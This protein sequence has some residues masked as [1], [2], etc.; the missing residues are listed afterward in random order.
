MKDIMIKITGRQYSGRDEDKVE[1][2]TA[3]TLFTEGNTT[4]ITYEETPLSGIEGWTTSLAI[5]PGKV[6]MFRKSDA[7][8]ETVMEF[9]KGRHYNGIY[10]TPYG[11]IS[12]ELLT[13][14]VSGF[15]D[16]DAKGKLSI[17]YDISLKGLAGSRN[18]LDIE[19]L[20]EN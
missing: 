1:F 9:E 3:G 11:N 4:H 16:A 19:I 2:I 13:N 20:G 5:S 8:P 17:D 18:T 7:V 12:M 14:E 6:K 15:L 10:A